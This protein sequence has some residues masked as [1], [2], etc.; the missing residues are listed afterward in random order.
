MHVHK[1]VWLEK[2]IDHQH[3]HVQG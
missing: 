2:D 1:R 3:T